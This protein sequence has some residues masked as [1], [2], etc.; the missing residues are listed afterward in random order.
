MSSIGAARKLVLSPGP[1]KASTLHADGLKRCWG[2]AF[3]TPAQAA[4]HDAVWGRALPPGSGRN[5][6]KQLIMQTFQSGLSWS[7]ILAKEPGFQARF[8]Q[9]DYTKVAQWTE[10][11]VTEALADDGIVRNGAKVRAAVANA[12]AAATLDQHAAGGFEAF[13]W[14]SCGRLPPAER[15]L[16]HESRSGSYM[17]ASERVDFETADGVHPTPGIMAAVAAFKGAG[18]R[19]LGPATML[20]FMQAAGFVNHHKPD[21]AMFAAAEAAYATT[22][23]A[24][25]RDASSRAA[26]APVT[27]SGVLEVSAGRVSPLP[28]TTCPASPSLTC[29]PDQPLQVPSKLRASRARKAPSAR[30][31][32]AASGKLPPSNVGALLSTASSVGKVPSKLSKVGPKAATKVAAKMAVAPVPEGLHGCRGGNGRRNAGTQ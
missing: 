1:L 29:N 4:Y 12:I 11:H 19:F 31:A 30:S 26:P 5:L 18:F 21:C 28:P 13:C 8:E 2:P 25:A 32:V 3:T 16:Q 23:A 7:T 15:L 10:A 20:S 6:F 14:A 27:P 24:L 9:W 22:S 17:R